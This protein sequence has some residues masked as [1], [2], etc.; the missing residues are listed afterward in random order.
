MTPEEALRTVALS[1]S[2]VSN[3]LDTRMYPQQA[4]AKADYPLAITN[5]ISSVYHEELDG[6]DSDFL[7]T[8]SIQVDIFGKGYA[9]AKEAA[10][11][12]RKALNAYKGTVNDMVIRRIR[13][14]SEMDGF[15]NPKNGKGEGVCRVIQDYEIWFLDS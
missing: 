1:N 8:V 10:T 14:T 6:L 15:D 11:A 2:L 7:A 12:L 4:P 13:L 9:T 5:R 3:L